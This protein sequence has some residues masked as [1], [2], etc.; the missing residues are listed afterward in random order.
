MA[1][2]LPT[3]ALP[4]RPALPPLPGGTQP[5][6]VQPLRK[7][8]PAQELD[9]FGLGTWSANTPRASR[10]YIAVAYEH[11][12]L[13]K[14]KQPTAVFSHSS[15]TFPECVVMG[16]LFVNGYVYKQQ[17]GR[18]FDFQ[19]AVLG[20][21]ALQGGGAVLDFVVY[22][23]QVKIGIRVE[24]VYHTA[25]D[26]FGRGTVKTYMDYNQALQLE[27]RRAVDLVMSVNLGVSGFPLENGPDD[28]VEDDL[29]RIDRI[30]LGGADER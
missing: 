19:G 7:L 22:R 21:R 3:I 16:W 5:S 26:P 20:G 12:G 15:G 14:T 11:F 24:S 13:D 29:R 9:E 17:G 28:A 1:T 4:S 25:M 10:R 2:G 30:Q 27:M 23:N 6:R 8:G 18:G